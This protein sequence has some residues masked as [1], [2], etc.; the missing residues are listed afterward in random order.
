MRKPPADSSTLDTRLSP[1]WPAY[2][3]PP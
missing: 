1:V 2:V 3:F